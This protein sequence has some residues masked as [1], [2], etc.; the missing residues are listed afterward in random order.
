MCFKNAFC[1]GNG[2]PC[3]EVPG[4]S[5]SQRASL[6]LKIAIQSRD[7]NLCRRVVQDGADMDA[8]YEECMECTPLLY[9][10]H[11]HRDKAEE[12]AVYLVSQ[13]ASVRGNSC[14]KVKD[15]GYS[16][17]HYAA[18]LG[19]VDLLRLLLEKDIEGLS[20]YSI[21][22]HPIHLA[23]ANGHA[24]CVQMILDHARKCPKS[25]WLALQEA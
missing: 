19:F 2:T 17:F 20:Q 4:R 9:T 13:G 12:I 5:V 3:V 1:A 23:I 10:L 24:V 11:Y 16:A 18:S 21:P 25:F 8:G 14:D 6:P 15:K 22:F 7:L